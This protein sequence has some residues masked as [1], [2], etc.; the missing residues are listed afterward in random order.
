MHPGWLPLLAWLEAHGANISE[1][2]VQPR[3][4]Q[5]E[6]GYGMYALQDIP[7]STPLFTVPGIA[8][9]NSITLRK[10]Y[11]KTKPGL[12][13]TQIIAL[14]LF[15]HRPSSGTSKCD[16]L[17]GPYIA[18]LPEDFDAHPLT[19]HVKQAFSSEG[20][21]NG[22]AEATFLSLLTPSVS[23]D[24]ERA[25]KAFHADWKRVH[26]YLTENLGVCASATNPRVSDGT[27]PIKSIWDFLWAWLNVNT[28]CIYYRVK[29]NRSDPNNLTLCPI[30][31]FA[32]HSAVH[33]TTW[34]KSTRSEVWN[35]APPRG[36]DHG[37]DFT[38]LSPPDSAVKEGD[39][40][41]LRY[42][43]HT[44]QFLFVE[45]GFVNPRTRLESSGFG[46]IDISPVVEALFMDRGA[47]G[48]WLKTVL[49][50]EGYW[51][52]WT[53]HVSPAPAHPDYRLTTALRLL[54]S[55]PSPVSD[56]SDVD[57]RDERLNTWR[58]AANGSRDAISKSNET[59]CRRTLERI[60]RGI[61]G[62]AG[63]QIGHLENV[64]AQ[65]LADASGWS[66]YVK[67]CVRTLWQEEEQVALAVLESIK[68]GAEF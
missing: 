17:F 56:I 15:L 31:D 30:L 65:Q 20:E 7:P 40:L 39:E 57:D 14:H 49:E 64:F 1:T 10:H 24:L 3:K 29:Q 55:F 5:D 2:R 61:A 19:W 36:K 66:E 9:L 26:D 33:P 28:R 67:G 23:Q 42:G 27:G 43:H 50:E 38:L 11:P 16:P 58:E 52:N 21:I 4:S 62:A 44:N 13:N 53:L 63:S 41:F 6:S 32:N 37:D 47:M 12:T 25:S 45:Y 68:M 35:V 34:P 51:G 60:C 46:D 59:R 48:Q 54:D 8:L 18:I 22:G